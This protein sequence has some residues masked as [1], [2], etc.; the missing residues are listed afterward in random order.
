MEWK[1][2]TAT[3]VLFIVCIN[4]PVPVIAPVNVNDVV[5]NVR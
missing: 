4:R 1:V 3:S 5:L 2:K